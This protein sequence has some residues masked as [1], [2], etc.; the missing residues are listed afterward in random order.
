MD[1]PH[2]SGRFCA[3]VV[4]RNFGKSE[5]TRLTKARVEER[6]VVQSLS[7]SDFKIKVVSPRSPVNLMKPKFVFSLTAVVVLVSAA[8]FSQAGGAS[9]PSLPA[10]P[11]SAGDPAALGANA[12]GVKIGAINV[13]QAIVASNEG[14]R[15]FEGLSK[16]LEPKQTD[17][18]AHSDEIDT[19]KKQLTTQ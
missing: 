3:V 4:A 7:E 2:H 10:A 17:L 11:S 18:K 5:P 14:Q 13:E 6:G 12:T 19:L 8:A 15:D 16:K 1:Y 9:S